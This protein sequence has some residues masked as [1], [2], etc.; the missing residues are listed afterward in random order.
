MSSLPRRQETHRLERS[1][2]FKKI[3][4]RARENTRAQTHQSLQLA[5]KKSG[6]MY[7]TRPQSIASALYH[8][9][10]ALTTRPKIVKKIE[11]LP[12]QNLRRHQNFLPYRVGFGRI[13]FQKISRRL[14]PL[15][16]FFSLK[17]KPSP[18]F[19]HHAVFDAGI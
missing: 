14:H 5:P 11:S 4:F 7:K 1:D 12:R 17:N 6:S 8:S 3:C 18:R 15:P 10:A 13:G 9:G 16:Q 19:G 2:A